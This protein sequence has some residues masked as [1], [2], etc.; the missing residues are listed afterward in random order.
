[1]LGNSRDPIGTAFCTAAVEQAIAKFSKP[2][3]SNTGPG[4][5]VTGI[6]IARLPHDHGIRVSIGG[7]SGEARSVPTGHP[8]LCA[9]GFHR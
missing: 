6:A 9:A 5:Q 7:K 3:T 4:S 8:A 2:E 1:M